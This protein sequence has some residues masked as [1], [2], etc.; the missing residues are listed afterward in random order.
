MKLDTTITADTISKKITDAWR[1]FAPINSAPKGTVFF[2]DNFPSLPN[3]YLWTPTSVDPTVLEQY[4]LVLRSVEEQPNGS[5]LVNA[6]FGITKESTT[7]SYKL[8]PYIGLSM[9]FDSTGALTTD[10]NLSVASGSDTGS[11]APLLIT[12][13]AALGPEIST[14]IALYDNVILLSNWFSQFSADVT[15]SGLSLSLLAALIASQTVFGVRA[16]FSNIEAGPSSPL[17][18]A[19]STYDGA[20]STW[21]APDNTSDKNGY[22][23]LFPIAASGS[24]PAISVRMWRPSIFVDD[25]TWSLEVKLDLLQTGAQDDH[26]LVTFSGVRDAAGARRI[27]ATTTVVYLSST[28]QTQSFTKSADATESGDRFD[29]WG[30]ELL[31]VVNRSP[32]TIAFAKATYNTLLGPLLTHIATAETAIPTSA[33]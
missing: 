12:P 16:A 31:T 19:W 18:T 24:D 11:I 21:S 32:E 8:D 5:F 33:R 29:A 15:T 17:R 14:V 10:A 22:A 13:I 20:F 2:T 25:K 9:M 1:T 4:G 27:S 30:G 28:G 6:I 26:I 23:Q 3:G 7:T